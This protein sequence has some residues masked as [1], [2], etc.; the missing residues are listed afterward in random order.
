MPMDNIKHNKIY[1]AGETIIKQGD[2]GDS[3][4]IIE[5]GRVE[6]L[7]K[8]QNGD[9]ENVG[10]RGEG[11]IIGEMG[12][13]DGSPRTATIKAIED[14][15]LLEITH[16][17]FGSRLES[18]D[19]V[20]Q[21]ISQVILTRYR[22]LLKRSKILDNTDGFAQIELLE[23]NLAAQANVVESVRIAN[24]LKDAL[25]NDDLDV[26]YQPIINLE[27]NK[28]SGME[29]LIRW[30]HKDLGFISPGVFIP[31]AEK[32]GMIIEISK[33]V[34]RK[35]LLGLENIQ[36]HSTNDNEMFISINF[37]SRDIATPQFVNGLLDTIS[38]TSI[39]KEQTK[40][41][42]TERVLIQQ[43]DSA[44]KT[45]EACKDAGFKIAIDDFG[46]GYSS[47]SYL[48]YFPIDTL[49]IDQSFIR[50]MNKEDKRK[51]LVKSIIDLGKNLNM[52]IIAEGVE[53]KDE[54]DA[55]REMGCDHVQGF[56]FAKPM[57]EDDFIAFMKDWDTK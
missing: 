53:E 19:P 36:K 40:L 55:L 32:S 27:T 56:Y 21:M 37:S 17:D 41:E 7:V 30:T 4:Y 43:P 39:K 11:T 10:T 2:I 42:I 14:C 31:V 29:A 15:R 50:S 5:E 34:F 22:D 28:I 20:I 13:V 16:D 25:A 23:K 12:I 57:P 38:D 1:K 26:H 8:K 52:D 24:E 47:L 33:W 44:K 48:Y 51:K 49:K 3:A 6:I 35:S 18:S 54:A 9:I 45:L 46:T